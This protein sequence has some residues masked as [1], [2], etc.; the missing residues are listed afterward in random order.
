MQETLTDTTEL[1]GKIQTETAELEVVGEMIKK[2]VEENTRIEQD[3]REFWEKYDS[4]RDRYQR[5]SDDIYHL[6]FMKTKRAH[7]AEI[8]GAFMFELM[9]RDGVV[10]AFD[11][12]LWVA[13]VDIVKV[14][15]GGKLVFKFKNG[16]EIEA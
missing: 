10:E 15:E 12:K 5:L 4:L 1:D 3:Q 14:Y 9:E 7:Q 16:A 13:S 6:N 8:I 2:A 11:D